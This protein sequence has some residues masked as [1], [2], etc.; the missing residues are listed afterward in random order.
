MKIVNPERGP[1]EAR[2]LASSL[3]P[4]RQSQSLEAEAAVKRGRGRGSPE[5]GM[6]KGGWASVLSHPRPD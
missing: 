5:A 3:V 4:A 1:D 6:G 2:E